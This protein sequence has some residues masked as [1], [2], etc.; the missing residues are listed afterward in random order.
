M[1]CWIGGVASRWPSGFLEVTHVTQ[2]KVACTR[3]CI[4][5]MGRDERS[6]VIPRVLRVG[7]SS[8]YPYNTSPS[9]KEFEWKKI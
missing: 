7:G 5:P 8:A 4:A 2:E 6:A 1:K 3:S 9:S